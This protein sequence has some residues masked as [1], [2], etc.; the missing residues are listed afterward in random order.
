MEV[1][2]VNGETGREQRVV[3]VL[4]SVCAPRRAQHLQIELEVQQVE[5]VRHAAVGQLGRVRVVV[6]SPDCE[7]ARGHGQG[8]SRPQGAE[9]VRAAASDL[10]QAPVGFNDQGT[11]LEST[12]SADHPT[13]SLHSHR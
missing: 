11:V 2:G 9:H 3:M 10:T 7:V 13:L 6:A 12:P 5:V 8:L 1:I 4:H